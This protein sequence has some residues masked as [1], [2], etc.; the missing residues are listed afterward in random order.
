VAQT[1]NGAQLLIDALSA[2]GVDTIFGMPGDGINGLMEAI[3]ERE[4]KIRFIQVRHEESAA[5]MACA[6]AKWTG[7]LGCCLATTGPGGI[8]LLN[9][10]YDAKFDRAP[11]IAVTG[12]PYHDLIDTFTQ[13]DVDL[14]KL[15]ADVAAH[16]TRIMSAA[17]VDNAVSLACRI[18]YAQRTVTHVSIPVDVQEEALEDVEASARNVAHHVSF[19]RTDGQRVADEDSIVRALEILNRGKRIA[20]LAGQGALGASDELI[21]LAELLGAPIVKALLGKAVVPDDHPLTTGGIGLL[22]TRASQEAFEECDTLLI[23]GSTFPYV[24]YYP[25]PGQARGVQ[26]DRDATR[27][28]L[29]FPVE[30]GLVGDARATL[31]VLIARAKAHADRSFLELAQRRKREWDELLERSADS[32]QA[33]LSPDRL[34]RDVGRRLADD[35]LVAWDSGHNTCVLARYIKVRPGQMFAGSGM[36]A[37]MGSGLTYAIAAAL[38][39]PGRQVVAFVGDGGLTMLLGEL[40]TVV[41]Y[42]LPIKIVV[43]KNNT[44]GQIKW[45]QL[46]FL[47]N[48]EYEC[49]L[50]PIDFVMVA[51]G[52]GL[53]GFRASTADE[54]A[55]ALDAAFA[56]PGPVLVEATVDPNVPLLPAKR[57]PKY[58]D[59]LEKALRSG[60]AGADEIRANLKREPARTQ[61]T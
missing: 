51:R 37:T 19:A 14:G 29:R 46:M 15:F 34:A 60:T 28:G 12:L 20:I 5:L 58:A 23:V 8:H 32:V 9:G 31:K 45:E 52:F 11:V 47:G 1:R 24:E 35:A 7:K 39:F 44:L 49:A 54:L 4:D 56:A 18:A 38:A 10:L 26:I 43:M 27:I 48:T 40:A 22:G 36:L 41:R 25:K 2:W 21:E 33:R 3:H 42:G 50:Q 17:H 57:M 53:A 61:L 6:H 13:Q 16:S 30:T 59:N 55:T